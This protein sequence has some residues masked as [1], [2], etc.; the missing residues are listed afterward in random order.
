LN[1]QRRFGSNGR[2]LQFTPRRHEIRNSL[3]SVKIQ[4]SSFRSQVSGLRSQVSGLRSQ[5][6]G[7]R[8]ASFAPLRA[9]SLSEQE[10]AHVALRAACGRLPGQRPLARAQVSGSATRN[11][12][13]AASAAFATDQLLMPD[14]SD[15]S[16]FAQPQAFTR[17]LEGFHSAESN[18]I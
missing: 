17:L 2:M 16:R 9:V 15:S 4:L 10:A 6:S 18:L 8:F 5:V 7:L 1:K 11:D 14:P 13:K 3:R 12:C